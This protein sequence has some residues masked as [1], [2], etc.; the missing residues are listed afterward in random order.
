MN[1][2]DILIIILLAVQAAIWARNGLLR[3]VLS[4]GS[5]WLGIFAGAMLAP[6]VVGWAADDESSKLL[7]TFIVIL[8][9]AF[10]FGTIG[11]MIGMKLAKLTYKV[12]LDRFD[13]ILGSAFGVLMT[14]GIV[15]LLAATA[16]G[17]PT[18]SL[19]R[20]ISNSTIIQA[21]NRTLP[22]APDV[23][24]RIGGLFKAGG[25]PQVFVG[26]QPQPIEPVN[27]PTSGEV[28][29]A[30]AAAGRSTVRIESAGCGGIVNGSGFVAAPNLVVT[31]AHVI[32]GIDEPTIV[33]LN[34][35][36]AAV[37]VVFDPELDIAILRT[38]GLAGEPLPLADQLFPRGTTGAVL[39]YPGGGPLDPEPAG[40]LRQM[41]AR[42]LDIYGEETIIRSVYELQAVVRSGNSGGPLVLSDGTVIGVIFARSQ[43]DENIG[44]AV[45]S[46]EIVPVLSAAQDRTQPVDTG[47]CAS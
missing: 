41:Q 38:S 6:Y 8:G 3:G 30:L 24:A 42:G 18:G 33:D 9:M 15:W 40:V 36:H 4:L 26:P 13:S 32:A 7:L 45:T 35:R 23:L 25:F 44:Y 1:I 27:P 20:Q 31:N 39:G 22:P 43:V 2:L 17:L 37:P 29:E 16:G 11:Q 19:N 14:L 10:L 21:M 12:K 5:F 34:G 28:A 46:P 47:V